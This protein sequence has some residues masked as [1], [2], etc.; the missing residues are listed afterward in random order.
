MPTTYT[1]VKHSCVSAC[2][3]TPLLRRSSSMPAFC[4]ALRREARPPAPANLLRSDG[5]RHLPGFLGCIEAPA[6]ADG[7]RHNPSGDTPWL[8][9]P[10][11]AAPS[12]AGRRHAAQPPGSSYGGLPLGA[13]HI[14]G[15]D[16]AG[17]F[18]IGW[19]AVASVVTAGMLDQGDRS[20]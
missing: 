10:R 19:P 1:P 5:G 16:A 12:S 20:G 7:S 13:D 11:S 3:E 6:S 9:A 4:H 2:C 8:Q 14:G 18:A 15:S 17:P